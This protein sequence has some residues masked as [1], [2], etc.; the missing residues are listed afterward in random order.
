MMML[1]GGPNKFLNFGRVKHNVINF[2]RADVI[3]GSVRL[4]KLDK[5]IG[6]RD[7]N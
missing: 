2:A 1:N 7:K 5:A 3:E 6:I 4:L